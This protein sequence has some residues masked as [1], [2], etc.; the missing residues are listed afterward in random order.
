M[1]RDML[2]S[3]EDNKTPLQSM[4]LI[5]T[6]QHMGL[7]HLF[8]EEIGSTLSSIYDNFAHQTHHGHNLFESSL[9]FRLFREHGYSVSPSKFFFFFF[10]HI[11]SIKFYLTLKICINL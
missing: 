11:N 5:D 10:L 1:V 7:D 9:F 6:L 4:V 2:F 8:K 3:K